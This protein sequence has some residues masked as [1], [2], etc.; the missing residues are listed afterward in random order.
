VG[1]GSSGPAF[2]N[3]TRAAPPSAVG[4]RGE[5]FASRPL[6][7]A[8]VL[9]AQ[10][11]VDVANEGGCRAGRWLH[12]EAQSQG[13]AC[14]DRSPLA[15]RHSFLRSGPARACGAPSTADRAAEALRAS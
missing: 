1:A 9:A 8:F 15:A 11:V 13:G 12:P 14:N 7:Y 10:G 6:A 2:G 5:R 4:E 3:V